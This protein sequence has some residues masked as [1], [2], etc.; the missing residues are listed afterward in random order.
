MKRI[1]LVGFVLVS[2]SS[3][4][5]PPERAALRPLPNDGPPL[6]YAELL[7]RARSQATIATEAFYVNRWQELEDAARGLEQT[8][9]YLGKAEDVPAKQKGSLEAHSTDL[10]KEAARLLEAARAKNVKDANT[11]LQRIH[12]MVRELRLDQ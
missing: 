1:F 4:Q 3:C 5:L 2:L 12:L 6:P 7:T 10:N 9:R 8:A 11:T